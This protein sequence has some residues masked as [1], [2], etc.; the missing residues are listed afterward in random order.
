MLRANIIQ[1]SNSPWSAPTFSFP[2]KGSDEIR[3]VHDYRLLNLKTVKSRFPITRI[4]DV[5]ANLANST[6]FSTFDLKCSFHQQP[7]HPDSVAKTAFSTPDGHYEYLRLTM[8]VSNGP[9][10]HTEHLEQFLA[11]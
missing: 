10:E 8:G 9:A 3:M 7:I 1:H 5:F 6:V 11:T 4:D 2:K